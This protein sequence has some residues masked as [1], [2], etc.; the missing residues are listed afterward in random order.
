DPVA[1]GQAARTEFAEDVASLANTVGGDLVF[2]V[3]E[4]GGVATAILGVAVP[5]P[6]A[7]ILRLESII[8]SS[9]E[10]RI[11]GVRMRAIQGGPNP[12]LV[13]RVPRGWWG[14]HMVKNDGLQRFVGRNSAGKYRLDVQQIRAGFLSGADLAERAR[15]F[16]SERVRSLREG[17]PPA[18]G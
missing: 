13:V 1:N 4:V 11:A 16:H 12:V 6:D 10:P 7:E 5:D 3:Q 2:G 17:G 18:D 9:I 8:Q 15:A 14:L